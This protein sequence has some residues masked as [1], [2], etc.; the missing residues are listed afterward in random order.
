MNKEDQ[1]RATYPTYE[2]Y[3]NRQN[4]KMT[5]EERSSLYRIVD[6]AGIIRTEHDVTLYNALDY[7]KAFMEEHP[8]LLKGDKFRIVEAILKFKGHICTNA[9][10]LEKEIE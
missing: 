9:C 8:G 5:D 3:M 2:E 1:I 4:S 7:V 10:E 6:L